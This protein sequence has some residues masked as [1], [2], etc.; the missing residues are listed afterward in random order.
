MRR[1]FL[2]LGAAA[3]VVLVG[4]TP[5]W[6]QVPTEPEG[7]LT[8]GRWAGSQF[9]AEDLRTGTATREAKKFDVEARFKYSDDV[10]K[11]WIDSVSA[12]ASD[13]GQEG[14]DAPKIGDEPTLTGKDTTEVTFLFSVSSECNVTTRIT[15][16][17]KT[18]PGG[19]GQP[20]RTADLTADISFDAPASAVTDIIASVEDTETKDINVS[21]TLPEDAEPDTTYFLERAGPDAGDEPEWTTIAPAEPEAPDDEED[22]EVPVTIEGDESTEP[23]PLSSPITD[24]VTDDGVYLYRVVAERPEASSADSD[25][26][27][28][29]FVAGT[30]D[31]VRVGEPPPTST[32]DDQVTPSSPTTIST[33]RVRT[34]PTRNR[35]SSRTRVTPGQPSSPTTVDTGFEENLPYDVD[36][37]PGEL[38]AEGQSVLNTDDESIVGPGA[39][40]AALL[41]MV[42]WAGHV[43]YF[44][45]LAAQF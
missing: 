36:E 44:R 5:A 34:A 14:C 13:P 42:G 8:Q 41:V 6:A 24:T 32:I 16:T 27:N 7:E 15:V 17:A 12:T 25:E 43:V 45:R 40:A 3:L 21:W 38:V 4:W 20:P 39:V 18:G 10:D 9:T 30:I 26:P 23:E 35:I 33:T 31:D 22:E 2:T 37:E 19:I 28:S 29:I 1:P 11:R